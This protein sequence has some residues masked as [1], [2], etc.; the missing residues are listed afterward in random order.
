M[1]DVANALRCLLDREEPGT[2]P[3]LRDV[4]TD[5]YDGPVEGAVECA[6][7]GAFF[8]YQ[9]VALDEETDEFVLSPI[10]REMFKGLAERFGDYFEPARPDPTDAL[11]FS[12]VVVDAAGEPAYLVSAELIDTELLHVRAIRG[13]PLAARVRELLATDPA[14]D[15]EAA[16]LDAAW[17]ALVHA[18]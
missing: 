16:A 10:T 9:M 2:P 7:G 14:S 3:F 8:L 1:P 13:D 12:E 6:P 15:A 5:F 17:L 11:A 18:G 4:V